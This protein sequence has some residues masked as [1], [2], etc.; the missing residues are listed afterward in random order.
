MKKTFLDTLLTVMAAVSLMSCHRDSQV[1][2][3]STMSR[4]YADMFLSD[5]WI[6]EAGPD[7]REKSDT[8]AFYEPVF[9]SYG[10][11]TED[12]LRSV[13]YYLRDPERFSKIMLK[14]RDRLDSEMKRLQSEV[15]KESMKSEKAASEEAAE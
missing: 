14:A 15:E 3:R 13:E 8:M 6:L 4:I 7:A 10:Y 12:Y 11:T 2:P 9:N 5:S 1:I